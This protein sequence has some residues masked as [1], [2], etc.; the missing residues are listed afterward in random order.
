M[1]D[2]H[3]LFRSDICICVAQNQGLVTT[4]KKYISA[5]INDW[6]HSITY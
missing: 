3:S 2:H 5:L 6:E 4:L 1:K